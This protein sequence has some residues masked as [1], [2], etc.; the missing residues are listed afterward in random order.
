VENK[1]SMTGLSIH[2]E[3]HVV[4]VG[5]SRGLGRAAVEEHLKRGWRVT[6]TVRDPDALADLRADALTVETLNITDWDAIDAL[7]HCLATPVDCLFVVA[8]IAGPSDVSIGEADPDKFSEMMLV[9]VCIQP[10]QA[11]Q[12]AG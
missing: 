8:G 7:G 6:A 12:L 4:I 10:P 9:N 5:A 11:P 1:L 2:A 3:R